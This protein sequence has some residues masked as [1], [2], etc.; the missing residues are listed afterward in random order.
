MAI[1]HNLEKAL[2]I[3]LVPTFDSKVL[4]LEGEISD[5]RNLRD[6]YVH[7]GSH[8]SWLNIPAGSLFSIPHYYYGVIHNASHHYRME[9][10]YEGRPHY[11]IEGNDIIL[12]PADFAFGIDGITITDWGIIK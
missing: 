2:H 3:E 7:P 8:E 1:H 6:D 5:D 11:K 10:K 12:F 9:K 4:P